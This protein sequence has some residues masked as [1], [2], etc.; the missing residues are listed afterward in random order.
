MKVHRSVSRPAL[1]ALALVAS[2]AVAGCGT[3]RRGEP[4]AGRFVAADTSVQRGGRVFYAYCNK[5]HDGGEAALA[6]GIHNKP[7]PGFMI[8]LQVRVGM[9]AMPSFSSAQIS[10]GEL[11][12]LIAYLKAK[13]AQAVATG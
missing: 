6:P 10:D 2:L 9:G 3:A 5:C 8:K 7:L 13:R 11:D 12:D 4:F 1:V